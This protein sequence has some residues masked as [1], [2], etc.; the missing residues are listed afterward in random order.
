MSRFAP[1][2]LTGD[3]SGPVLDQELQGTYFVFNNFTINARSSP[4]LEGWCSVNGVPFLQFQDNKA[5]PLG[6]L[7]KVVNTIK[8]WTDFTERQNYIAEEL[9]NQILNT[10]EE[11]DKTMDH[12]TWQVIMESQYKQGQLSD[13]SWKFIIGGQNFF[14]FNPVTK[15]WGAIHDKAIGI[16]KKWETN[17]ELAMDLARFSKEDS[18]Y[19]LKEFSKHWKEIPSK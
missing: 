3:S 12:H 16:M 8:E 18:G 2:V 17:T 5:M 7:G 13:A 1:T 11:A 15:R 9:R 4:W 6:D 19:Y 10:E 14:Y